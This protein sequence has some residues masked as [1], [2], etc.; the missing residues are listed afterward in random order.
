MVKYILVKECE[1]KEQE[2]CS[3]CDSTGD[4]KKNRAT[5]W[6]AVAIIFFILFILY[7]IIEIVLQ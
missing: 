1:E 4:I 2:E 6:G 3:W 5:Y 7:F